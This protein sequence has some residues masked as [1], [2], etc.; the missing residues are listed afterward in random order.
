VPRPGAAP[1][2]DHAV[3]FYD[4]ARQAV[5]RLADYVAEGLTLELPVVTVLRPSHTVALSEALTVLGLDPGAAVADGRLHLLE[6]GAT[7]ETFM[8]EGLPDPQLMADGVGTLIADLAA[9][10]RPVRA[11]GEM[12]EL[13]WAE[14]NVTGALALESVWN[15][16][17]DSIGFALL[18]PYPARVLATG[19]LDTVGRL[20]ALHTDVVAPSTYASGEE[21]AWLPAATSEIFVPAPEAV[22]ATRR[23]VATAITEWSSRRGEAPDDRLVAD[24]CLVASELAANAVTHAHS[25]FEVTVT[26]SHGEVRV[27]V[28]DTGPGTAEEHHGRMLAL[29]GRGLAIVAGLADRWGCDVLPG[30][31]KVVWAELVARQ[32]VAL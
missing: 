11:A 10:G 12:V 30:G 6:A 26:C 15:G 9:G 2:R 19:R 25:A 16:L 28:S 21:A 5:A 4:D 8:V 20:C 22:G 7:L 23:L 31:G 24:A 3:L 27:S 13:L 14:G 32:P 29:S 1:S 17:A 18:C